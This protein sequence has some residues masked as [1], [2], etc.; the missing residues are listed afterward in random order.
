[1]E[2]WIV[3]LGGYSAVIVGLSG[4]LGGVIAKKILAAE[5]H[6]Y[7]KDLEELK[8]NLDLLNHQKK[9][10]LTR[11]ESLQSKAL[12]DIHGH[13]VDFETFLESQL[14]ETFNKWIET[15]KKSETHLKKIQTA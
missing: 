2:S 14:T 3:Y 4:W 5:S 11:F 15:Q 9:S 8:H 10:S 12:G 7:S 6:R 1:M 13:L